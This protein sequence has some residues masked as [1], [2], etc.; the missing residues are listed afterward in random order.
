LNNSSPSCWGNEPEYYIYTH[1]T[2]QTRVKTPYAQQTQLGLQKSIPL[3]RDLALRFKAEAFNATNT[4]IFGSA[5]TGSPNISPKRV[6]SVV[7]PNQPGAWTGYGTIGSTQQ[8]FPR[9]YQ[10][11]L[12]LQF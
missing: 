9:Q 10:L 3:H 5:S 7:N 1:D 11:S 8:N 6:A 4:P 12:K 2:T